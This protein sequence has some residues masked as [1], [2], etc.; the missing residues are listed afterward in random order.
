MLGWVSFQDIHGT[1]SKN[2]TIVCIDHTQTCSQ[3]DAIGC[4]YGETRA[5]HLTAL[6]LELVGSK[7]QGK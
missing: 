7:Y 3:C 4:L 6:I 5:G 1:E 2:N